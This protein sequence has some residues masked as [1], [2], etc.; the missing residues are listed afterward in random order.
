MAPTAVS[1]IDAKPSL[2]GECIVYLGVLN[3]FFTVDEAAP[4]VSRIGK[5]VGRLQL[6]ITPCV[7]V[8]QGASSKRL[9][10]VFAPYERADV[11]SA[12]EQVHEYMDRPLQ[13][14]VELRQLSQLAPQ[15]FSQLSLRYTF[16]RETSTQ[17]PR[18]QVDANGDSGSL[19]LEFRHVVDV[20]DA[21]VKYVTGSNLSIEILGHTSAE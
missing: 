2:L 6:R 7:A 12:E 21:L 20:S 15:R 14:R 3:Y 5:V 9:E 19:G 16:F 18:F 11:D 8:M 13:Y 4:V 1:S 17:T 10:D